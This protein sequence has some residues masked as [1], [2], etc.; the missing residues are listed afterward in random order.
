MLRPRRQG[1]WSA[2]LFH[3]GAEACALAG[4]MRHQISRELFD[5]WDSLRGE[6]AAPERAHVNPGAIGGILPDTFLIEADADSLFP[7]RV[8][9]ARVNALWRA[10]LKGTPFLELWRKMD[11]SSV[12]AALMAVVDGVTPIV[13]GARMRA[14]GDAAAELE[15]LLLPLRHFGRTHSRVLG[16]L[17]PV[18]PVEW[19]GETSAGPLE[20][21]SMRIVDAPGAIRVRSPS[22]RRP[23]PRL[24]VSNPEKN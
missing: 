2:R 21:L 10:E 8:A 18:Q 14:P 22:G 20:F 1:A 13:G 5:Y 6:R 15:L 19:I 4:I 12:H 23:R 16:A 17:S 11:R 24:V 9:G 7:V 3:N